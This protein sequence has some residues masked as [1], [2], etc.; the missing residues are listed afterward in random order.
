MLVNLFPLASLFNQY[1][2]ALLAGP[3]GN[4]IRIGGCPHHVDPPPRTSPPYTHPGL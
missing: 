1:R 2:C 4:A 3:F